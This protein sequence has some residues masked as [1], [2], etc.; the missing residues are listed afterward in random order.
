[1]VIE[2]K[3]HIRKS[4]SFL[5]YFCCNIKLRPQ[6]FFG[7]WSSFVFLLGFMIWSP[8]GRSLDFTLLGIITRPCSTRH[9]KMRCRNLCFNGKHVARRTSQTNAE[10]RGKLRSM[11]L[12]GC[13]NLKNSYDVQRGILSGPYGATGISVQA[14]ED[15]DFGISWRPI[16]KWCGLLRYIRVLIIYGFDV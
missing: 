10:K 4:I 8:R 6:C 13:I 16:N 11:T 15:L 5:N 1:M 2:N 9:F 12:K 3:I 14:L 7:F